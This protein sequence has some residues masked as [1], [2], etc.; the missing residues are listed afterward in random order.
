MLG[1]RADDAYVSASRSRRI[2]RGGI[3]LDIRMPHHLTFLADGERHEVTTTATTVRSAMAEA[4]VALRARDRVSTDLSAQ[5]YAE[6]VVALTRVDGKRVVEERPIKFDTKKRKTDDHVRGR[7]QGRRARA[8]SA[9]RPAPSARPTSTAS[10]TRA[11][12]QQ[13]RHREAG[14][15]GAARRHQGAAGQRCRPPTASTGRRWPTASPAA[16]R[17]PTTRPARSTGCTSSWRAPGAPSAA[18]ACRPRPARPSRP[19]GRRS[20]T[21]AAVPGSGRSAAS[22]LFS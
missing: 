17:R 7:D 8:R 20:S 3:T 1:V 13:G 18:S 2:N 5:P 11:A 15:R 21:T 6:Q 12:R 14:D 9:S 22:Y 4:G 19:T 16:T 10:S